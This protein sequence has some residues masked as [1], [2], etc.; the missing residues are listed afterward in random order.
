MGNC[1]F[2]TAFVEALIADAEDEN[3]KH[4]MGGNIVPYFVNKGTA[5]VYDFT[6][7]DA[8]LDREGPNY[9]RDVG[10]IDA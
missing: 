2:N 5:Q 10:T 3:S 6:L 1:I 9:W 8:G 4:D 7:N